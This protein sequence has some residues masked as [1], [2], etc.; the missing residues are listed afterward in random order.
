[1]KS[2][3]MK[4]AAGVFGLVAAGTV[5]A[6]SAADLPVPQLAAAFPPVVVP[7]W[8]GLYVGVNIGYADDDFAYPYTI[9]AAGRTQTSL[10]AS[11]NSSNLL[12]GGQI[13]YNFAFP[14][15]ALPYDGGIVL[16]AEADYDATSIAGNTQLSAVSPDGGTP[17][18]G[19]VGSRLTSLGTARGRLGLSF[20][21]LLI[22]GTGGFAFGETHDISNIT[23]GRG[24]F[25]TSSSAM[26]TGKA[27]GGGIEFLVTQN[28]TFK[29]EYLRA[30]LDIKPIASGATIT[31]S[32]GLSGQPQANIVRGG[33]NYK[34]D[35]FNAPSAPV[36]AAY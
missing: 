36:V 22:F 25:T 10:N 5:T 6:A 14:H 28:V 30:N 18:G 31:R 7:A 9:R 8:G 1:M 29:L 20:G 11:L 34:F 13:G 23:L 2:A 16:G 19:N 15:I 21:R 3:I 32:F 17:G 4:T 26:H 12:G 35:F 24:A 33:V 27:Y